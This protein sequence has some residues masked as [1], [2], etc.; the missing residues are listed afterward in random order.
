MLENNVSDQAPEIG[1]PKNDPFICIDEIDLSVPDGWTFQNFIQRKW[2]LLIGPMPD[3][4][5]AATIASSFGNL[6]GCDRI[7]ARFL[8]QIPAQLS[9]TNRFYYASNKRGFWPN[10]DGLGLLYDLAEC[11]LREM[12]GGDGEFMGY[13]LPGFLP[14]DSHYRIVVP[15]LEFTPWGALFDQCSIFNLNPKRKVYPFFIPLEL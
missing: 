3:Y 7:T 4:C 14:R 6:A 13:D 12:V 5:G 10:R 15:V 8:M 9:N 11:N 1:L 2:N